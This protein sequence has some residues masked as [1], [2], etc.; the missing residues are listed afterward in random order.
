LLDILL[1]QVDAPV[2]EIR[3]ELALDFIHRASPFQLAWMLQN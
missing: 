2:F 3:G 1:G